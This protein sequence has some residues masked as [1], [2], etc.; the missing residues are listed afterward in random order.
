MQK[1]K[2][3]DWHSRARMKISSQEWNVQARM[4]FFFVGGGMVF[5]AFDQERKK[6]DKE[7]SHKGIWRSD[8]PETSQGQI[9]EEC[10]R[11][12]RD[13]SR[14][15]WDVS[16]GQTGR[17][18]GGGG[19]PAKILYVYWFFSFPI[20]ARI[21]FFRSPGSLTNS[22]SLLGAF[23]E[24]K[25]GGTPPSLLSETNYLDSYPRVCAETIKCCALCQEEC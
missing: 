8:A 24:W 23:S 10:P 25:C 5:H 19:G 15:R 22:H 3:W 2:A 21:I 11:D 20:R 17:T 1:N 6:T 9:R 12:R 16:P 4:F 13:I 14:D 18:P 7:K